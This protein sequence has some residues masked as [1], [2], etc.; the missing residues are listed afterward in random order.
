[1]LSSFTRPVLIRWSELELFSFSSGNPSDV[2]AQVDYQEYR[3]APLD[4]YFYEW[5]VQEL[6]DYGERIVC[7][8]GLS[9]IAKYD[10]LRQF[11]ELFQPGDAVGGHVFRTISFQYRFDWRFSRLPSN[12]AV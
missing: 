1:M 5:V 3:I 2:D 8:S 6:G 12:S 4:E 10:A 9:N 7:Q 11:R